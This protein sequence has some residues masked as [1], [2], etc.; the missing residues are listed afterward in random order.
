MLSLRQALEP[1]RAIV[2]E[3]AYLSGDRPMYADYILFGAF[4]WARCISP[5]RLLDE[6]DPV[7]AW[8]E[9]M[10]NLYGGLGLQAKGYAV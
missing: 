4:Q 1:F 8:R 9:R 2:R 3:R 7:A 6:G 5:F 10:L